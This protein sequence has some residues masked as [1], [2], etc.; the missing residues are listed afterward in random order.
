MNYINIK[1]LTNKVRWEKTT[2]MDTMR[3]EKKI[4]ELI[5]L[6]VPLKTYWTHL[7][8]ILQIFIIDLGAWGLSISI[9]IKL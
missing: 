6:E 8:Y 7:Q 2:G 9:Y 4:K 5:R 1:S 3:F